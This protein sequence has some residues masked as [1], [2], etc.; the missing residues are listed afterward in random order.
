MLGEGESNTF[1]IVALVDNL[2]LCTYS[3]ITWVQFHRAKEI[4]QE[5]QKEKKEEKYLEGDPRVFGDR[6][7]WIDVLKMNSS[8]EFFKNKYN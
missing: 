4:E 8:A 2:Y 7:C 3:Y 5:E 6:K 1:S